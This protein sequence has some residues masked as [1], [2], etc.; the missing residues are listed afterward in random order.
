MW[1]SPAQGVHTYLLAGDKV[2]A[3]TNTT[4]VKLDAKT[5]AVE[6]TQPARGVT[7]LAWDGKRLVAATGPFGFGF[8]EPPE[9]F[10]PAYRTREQAAPIAQKFRGWVAVSGSDVIF[11]NA[12]GEVAC[13]EGGEGGKVAWSFKTPAYTSLLLV[14]DGKVWFASHQQG[15]FG[16]D[17]KTG[18]IAW[19]RERI[20]AANYLPFL[21]EGKPAFWSNEG[22]ILTPE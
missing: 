2:Y 1:D 5:G 11:S 19:K 6:E 12:D 8:F 15:L 18:S 7:A 13:F 3:A 10:K 14:H 9:E 22:W 17:A 21:W 16:L 20:D 4:L